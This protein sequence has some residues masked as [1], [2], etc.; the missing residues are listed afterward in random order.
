MKKVI[1]ANILFISGARGKV[2]VRLKLF[3]PLFVDDFDVKI[4]DFS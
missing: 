4:I 1:F 2:V 3:S